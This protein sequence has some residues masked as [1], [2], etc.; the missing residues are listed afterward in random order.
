MPCEM[1]VPDEITIG[2]DM[3]AVFPCLCQCDSVVVHNFTPYSYRQNGES[4]TQTF[5]FDQLRRKEALLR[6]LYTSTPRIDNKNIDAYAFKKV[7]LHAM[8]AMKQFNARAEYVRYMRSEV[9]PFL[10]EILDRAETPRVRKKIKFKYLLLKHRC[11]S[12][13]WRIQTLVSC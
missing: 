7:Y 13:L 11:Y 6:Y 9:T 3:S 10:Q 12:S 8:A 5:H 1:A 4:M 2:E